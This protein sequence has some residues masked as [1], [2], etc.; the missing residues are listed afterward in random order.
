[1]DELCSQFARILGSVVAE[2]EA[3]SDMG[4]FGFNRHVMHQQCSE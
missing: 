2:D 3:L 4:G 1:V